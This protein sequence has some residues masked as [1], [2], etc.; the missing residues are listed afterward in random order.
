MN[1]IKSKLIMH[2]SK[3]DKEESQVIQQEI[4]MSSKMDNRTFK[5][6]LQEIK[7]IEVGYMKVEHLHN[8]M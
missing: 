7:S 2:K 4:A 3:K 5:E 1:K 6:F 8:K